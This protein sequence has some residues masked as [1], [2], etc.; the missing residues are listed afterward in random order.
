MNKLFHFLTIVLAVSLLAACGA[1]K[2]TNSATYDRGVI[3]NGIRWATRNVDAPGTFAAKPE[4][5]GMFFQ[6]NRK[7]AW[8]AADPVVNSN[9]GSVWD[10]SVPAGSTWETANDPSP[11]GWRVPAFEEMEALMDTAKVRNEWM[12]ENGINGRKF[13]DKTSGNSIFLPAAGCRYRNDGELNNVGVDGYYRSSSPGGRHGA[14]GI[15]FGRDYTTR[16]S[17][18]NMGHSVRCVAK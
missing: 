1:S 5:S 15:S 18:S 3:I 14:Y 10:S 16:N 13:T 2:K 17:G 12:I 7:T 9:G 6:W 11:K 4:D 8:S